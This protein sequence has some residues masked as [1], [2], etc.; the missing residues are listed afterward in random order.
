MEKV[1]RIYSPSLKNETAMSNLSLRSLTTT[2]RKSAGRY[3]MTWWSCNWILTATH[4]LLP[5]SPLQ[6]APELSVLGPFSILT[7]M[8]ILA[9]I[10]LHNKKYEILECVGQSR[11][12]KV[13]HALICTGKAKSIFNYHHLFSLNTRLYLLENNF[14]NIVVKN[15]M[16]LK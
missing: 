9:N 4:R 6:S 1:C 2:R 7:L 12:F 15:K 11:I 3:E 14:C 5:L 13:I 10:I 8:G 16:F